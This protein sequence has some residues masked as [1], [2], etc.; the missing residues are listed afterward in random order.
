[1]VIMHKV[2]VHLDGMLYTVIKSKNQ[3]Q[4]QQTTL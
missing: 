4:Y 2:K 1:M 3:H